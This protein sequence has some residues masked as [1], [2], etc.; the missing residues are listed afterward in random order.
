MDKDGILLNE[1]KGKGFDYL[2]ENGIIMKKIKNKWRI[3]G[4]ASSYDI[5]VSDTGER[6]SWDSDT[7]SFKNVKVHKAKARGET[8][9]ELYNELKNLH[10]TYSLLVRQGASRSE[11]SRIVNQ[12]NNVQSRYDEAMGMMDIQEVG[13]YEGNTTRSNI[14]HGMRL[15][16]KLK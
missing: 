4:I 13:S 11:L 14:M 3:T 2:S 15:A 12:I 6:Y 5:C 1:Q 8:A 10:L 16:P 9:E 7:S